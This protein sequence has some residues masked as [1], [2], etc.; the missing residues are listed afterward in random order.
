MAREQ[1]A[2]TLRCV[3]HDQLAIMLLIED[4]RGQCGWQKLAYEVRMGNVWMSIHVCA[5]LNSYFYIKISCAKLAVVVV[6]IE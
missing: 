4:G 3:P 1:Q 2:A 6:I 5:K